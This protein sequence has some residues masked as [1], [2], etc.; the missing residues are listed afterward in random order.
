MN[1]GSLIHRVTVQA[2]TEASDGHDGVVATW[3]D[4]ERLRLAALV[5]PLAG[6]DLDRAR[7]VDP[8]ASH[9]VT[10]RF[11][12]SYVTDLVGG[13]SRLVFHDG[14]VGDRTLEIVEPPRE[15][16]HRVALAM[17]CKESQ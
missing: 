10:L 9:R 17:T 12:G 3:A 13:R 8:R 1:A 6:R 11:W 15:T 7:Q 14:D 5:E 16:E 4:T 2:L